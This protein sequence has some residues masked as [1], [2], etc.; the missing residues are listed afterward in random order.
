MGIYVLSSMHIIAAIVFSVVVH[1]LGVFALTWTF[2]VSL[3]NM[4]NPIGFID[5]ETG[6]TIKRGFFDAV[7]SSRPKWLGNPVT[8]SLG[9][10]IMARIGR[11]AVKLN[12]MTS[13]QSVVVERQVHFTQTLHVEDVED[14]ERDGRKIDDFL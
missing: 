10:P 13:T 6:D 8:H 14:V 3:W 9:P 7:W 1:F 2:L 4:A 5:R 11:K 12:K